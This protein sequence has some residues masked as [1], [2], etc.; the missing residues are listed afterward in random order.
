MG[1]CASNCTILSHRDHEEQ[2]GT[3]QLS[4]INA[5][6]DD[7]MRHERLKTNIL[8]LGTGSS[9]KS[10]I[11]RTIRD[12][13]GSGFCQEELE[14]YRP[15]IRQNIVCSVITL[16]IQSQKLINYIENFVW[17]NFG[18]AAEG[19][20]I[21][22]CAEIC[23]QEIEELI[24][25]QDMLKEK[26]KDCFIEMETGSPLCTMTETI[27]DY[28]EEDF[29]G[30]MDLDYGP[31]KQLGTYLKRVWEMPQIQNIYRRRGSDWIGCFCVPEN[32]DYFLNKAQKIMS[33]DYIPTKEDYI[34]SRA[35]TIGL[36]GCL[37]VCLIFA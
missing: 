22:V 31:L 9:G 21:D 15:T 32:I 20:D 23:K 17:K 6:V 16:L 10:T 28:I 27:L 7:Q 18:A 8:L 24:K 3:R 2:K 1:H 19:D 37:F 30:D 34:K 35:R 29:T 33:K 12:I 25:K 13:T 11:F 14:G 5:W 4:R 26:Y 36:F